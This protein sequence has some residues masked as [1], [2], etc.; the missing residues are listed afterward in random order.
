MNQYSLKTHSATIQFTACRDAPSTRTARAQ[1]GRGLFFSWSEFYKLQLS[2][3]GS[4]E[5]FCHFLAL[6]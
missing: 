3:M 1:K 2:L 4:F 5:I 6:F